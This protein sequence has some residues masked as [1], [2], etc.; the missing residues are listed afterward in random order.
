ML[1][2]LGGD[3]EE[4]VAPA[5]RP[6]SLVA[7]L[8]IVP[9]L[10]VRL[11]ALVVAL[12][13]RILGLVARP[14]TAAYE[15]LEARYPTLLRIALRRR[16]V[17]LLASLGICVVSV[18]LAG[19]H[20]R[21]LMPELASGEFYVQ[22][23]LPQGASLERTTATLRALGEAVA[24]DEAVASQFV[25]VGSITQAGSASGTVVGV[26]LAQLDIRLHPGLTASQNAIEA[27]VLAA[28][29][30]ANPER[31]ATLRLGRP[32]LVAF[33]PPIQIQVFA[34]DQPR[35][36]AHAKALLPELEAVPRLRE[37]T[38][39]DL[40][41]RP[42]VRIRFDRERLGR[43]GIGVDQAALAV[44]RAI[45]GEVA[46]QLHAPDRQLDVRVQL[47]R[48]DRAKVEDV[49]RIQVGVANGIPV[50]LDAV[51]DVEPGTG[52]AEMRRI[53]GR[54][55][56]RIQ[57]RVD[58]VD[59]GGIAQDVQR[60]LDAHAGDDPEVEAMIA[61]QAD[62]MQVSLRSLA[63]TAAVSIFLV[64]VVMA[65]TFES[66]LHPFLIMFTV[67]MALAGVALGIWL[68]Q[69]P[70]SAMV[71]IGVIVL[72]GIVVNNAIVLVAAVNDRR[73]EGMSVGD[74][75]V[76]AGGLRL[77][78]ILMTTVTT[79]LGLLPMAMGLGEGA[80]LR[81][82]LAVA[83]MGGL[84]LSTL[85]TLV[86]IPCVYSLLP[87]KVREAWGLVDVGSLF[88]EAEAQR[89]RERRG[90]AP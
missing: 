49:R 2:S 50:R 57:A 18:R 77:R 85:L 7:L 48:V 40:R 14:F 38:P 51:A 56:L 28:V 6:R 67:P 72:G 78:P 54:R 44:Q 12:V 53:D 86:V 39:D 30:A 69:L 58:G 45:Q 42:E 5:R 66:L 47:P 32:S 62:E 60:A 74:A 71:G 55:G 46:T 37:V 20:G 80:A 35:A 73:G 10:L 29:E 88:A 33:G 52:P 82:P 68:A 41:G 84:G 83:V 8:V 21:T 65:S 9:A 19:A 4:T 1:Q 89:E 63:F 64:Y 81:Q 3:G 13:G 43:L 31:E 17:V 15:A 79:L 90:D 22:V 25:R 23:Q 16:A 36:I 24:H 70:I 87:G 26:H 75:L 61:G 34:E 59:L 11:V 27:R 76:E